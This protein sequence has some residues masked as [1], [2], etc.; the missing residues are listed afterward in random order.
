M[1][2]KLTNYSNNSIWTFGLMIL[3]LCLP[4]LSRGNTHL[5]EAPKP[6]TGTITSIESG[7]PLIG[8]TIT[9]KGTSAGT[10]TDVNG[11][12]SIDAEEGAVLIIT[13]T[14]FKMQEV[15]VGAETV[16]NVVLQP[17]VAL[18]D[19]VVVIGYGTQKKSHLT[20]SVSKVENKNLDQIA[21]AR[22]DEALIGQVSGVNIQASSAEA[23]AAPTITI[24][25]F[26]SVNANTG[27]AVIVDGLVVDA[28]F[29]GNLDMND[30][31]SFEILKDAASAAIYGSEGS[32]GVIMI[33]T[34]SGQA[35]KT[36]FSYETYFGRK[37]AF[38]SDAY[39]K[40]VAEWAAKELAENGELSNT[41]LYAQEIVAVTG[42]DRDWQDVFFDGGN[43]SSHSFSARGGSDRTTFSASLRTL[44]DEGVVITD[45]YRIYAGKLKMDTRIT[46]NLKFGL[47]ATPSYSKRRALPTSIHN[48]IRQSPWLPIYHTEETLQFIDRNAYPDVGVGDYFLEN[49]LINRDINGDGS[50][51]RPRTSGD[52]NPYA[53]YVER[54]HYEFRTNL[55]ASTYLNYEIAEGLTART[56]LG[57]T[58]ENRKRTRWNGTL[59][60]A[61]AS[62]A[63]YQL[64]NRSRTRLISDNTISY[65]KQVNKHEFN[66]LVGATFQR[67]QTENSIVEGTGYANDLLKNLQ[68]ATTISEFEE[69][70]IEK[71]KIGYFGRVNYVFDNRY[72][73][74]AS[75]RRDAS[76]VFGV[77]S[78]WGNF[79]AVSVGWNAHNERFLNEG[80]LLSRLKFR[81]SYGLTGNENFNVGDDIINSYP[82]LAL[83]NTSNAI[84][85][86]GITP[87]ISALNIANTLLQWEASREF[88]PG[89]DFGLL[90]NRITGSIDYYVRTSDKLLLENPVSYVTGFS[91]GIVNLGEVRNSGWE[92]ELR[93]RNFTRNK[94]SWSTTLIAS[95]NR[96]ELLNFGESDGALLEDGFGR[97]S[98]W[99]NSVGNPISSFY[100]F[101]VDEELAN[102][103]WDSPWIPI[104]GT[105]E[106]VIVKDLN[107]DGL[108]T[109][110]DKTILGDPYPEL[111]WS[112]TNEFSYGNFD[113]SFMIQ[114]SL[115]AEVKNI[116]DQYF[117]T[118]W[119]G[120][121]SDE[122]AVVDAGII[123]HVSF[124]QPKVLTN[125]VVQ[126]ASYFSLRNVNIGYNF[127]R[128]LLSR[129]GLG[130]LR[131][132]ASSQNLFYITSDEYD[133][134]NPEFIDT[135]NSPRAY[136]SQRAGTPLFRTVTFGLNV[137]F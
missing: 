33:T 52:M 96:N 24:R 19:D 100:G 5:A 88:N 40:S 48:P 73:V 84:T 80:D 81:V 16:Y 50:S 18:L 42:I 68:G 58:L 47:S 8:A 89:L 60:H 129:W 2:V 1:S 110:E 102:E 82:Y 22:V 122:Q 76:S 30:I 106:D 45:N 71:N 14:G 90:E 131:V 28:D 83:L 67:R 10:I 72:L 31:E 124:L 7:L 61:Q 26:G 79:P 64:Q 120:R 75:F 63:S 115:G 55:L 98:Q 49:H 38:G 25:G 85:E 93:T 97:N 13:Y 36:Q 113:F 101:V 6:I 104:N 112:L 94:F 17:D 34:K 121:T 127:S 37:E 57:I 126:N 130:G 114:G 59:H 20:G 12:F 105:A 53:Q 35:G 137:D 133:G 99:I 56:S 65:N 78:K 125:D 32:N 77:D 111:I 11:N 135:N 69:I 3:L 86:N 41:T 123:P 27:P 62:R 74:N 70:N 66:V 44:G 95:T 92:L 134:F 15:T 87:G 43:I 29:L 39:K 103:F 136:G 107:G 54:E 118:H 117:E 46:D 51:S 91:G 119:Q 116:G 108:I 128:E 21:V 9:V 132:Y 23:G 109:E 4:F